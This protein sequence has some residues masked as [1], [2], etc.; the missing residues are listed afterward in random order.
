MTVLDLLDDHTSIASQGRAVIEH[1]LAAGQSCCDSQSWTAG[2]NFPPASRTNV[3]ATLKDESSGWLELRIWAEM[4]A[5]AQEQRIAASNRAERGGVDPALYATYLEAAERAEHVARLALVRC[6]RRVV[7]IAIREWATQSKG[8]G[9][10][11]L[12]RLLGH[13]GHP[14][15]AVQHSWTG[16]GP[17][18]V[19]IEG[20][21]FD[22]AVAQLWQYC[23]HGQSG[24]A[25]RGMTA[26]ELAALGNPKLKMLV[27]LLAEACMKQ[28]PGNTY[29][30]IYDFRRAFTGGQ[31][32]SAPCV[33]CG[34]AGRP[35]E[36]GSPWSK[37]HQHA[38]ALRVVGKHLLRDLWIAGG[39]A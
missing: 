12:A 23:G 5:D 33:R 38:D 3:G 32:H 9:D 30:D 27:H 11:L 14:V 4:F 35:A 19:L 24:R 1:P 2:G 34:P 16:T 36:P 25:R 21:P 15:H 39:A 22:R 13:L 18:R 31:L 26:A 20:E 37:G 10:H 17:N 28:A 8:V 29:R 7:P 6:Y